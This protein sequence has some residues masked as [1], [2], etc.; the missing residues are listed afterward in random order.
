MSE[1][2]SAPVRPSRGGLLTIDFLTG[3]HPERRDGRPRRTHIV[4]SNLRNKFVEVLDEKGV[5][6]MVF[7]NA[8][9]VVRRDVDKVQEE[10]AEAG[11]FDDIVDHWDVDLSEVM[12]RSSRKRARE[13][14]VDEKGG[15]KKPRHCDD[16]DISSIQANDEEEEDDDD[17]EGEDDDEDVGEDTDYE[18]SEDEEDD[19]D[20]E[21][22]EEEEDVE[23]SE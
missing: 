22:E 19:D 20:D 11:E 2:E 12:G 3:N 1:E 13:D 23:E 18:P 15:Q 9:G 6:I 4:S 8:D 17:E 14:D 21:E 7:V 16:S 10:L 5:R